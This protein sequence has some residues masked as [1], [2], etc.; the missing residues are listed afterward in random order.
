MRRE[1]AK[2][3]FDSV[4]KPLKQAAECLHFVR[5]KPCHNFANYSF[6]L[7]VHFREQNFSGLREIQPVCPAVLRV[8]AALD[9]AERFH[10]ADNAGDIAFRDQQP[11]RKFLL[12]DALLVVEG[13]QNIELRPG[14]SV[15][16]E[17]PLHPLHVL[18]V[19]SHHLH[20]GLK[21]LVLNGC[22]EFFILHMYSVVKPKRTASETS[23]QNILR[24]NTVF[25]L[26]IFPKPADKQ[27]MDT[28]P[29][30][31]LSQA[32]DLGSARLQAISSNISNVNTPGFKRQDATFAALLDSAQND[33]LAQATPDP[34]DLTGDDD[35]SHPTLT[36][37]Q[38]GSM[39]PDG[40][41]IDID[42]ET[43]RMAAAQIYYEG[44]AQLLSG[45]FS[46]LKYV[47]SGGK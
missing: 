34:R 43:S 45:Q 10:A 29:I 13:G 1:T 30:T 8:R 14:H 33:T 21:H 16:A 2:L 46:N 42:A 35:P 22:L 24:K 39:R 31:A 41:N 37:Q 36:V 19:C 11:R 3:F 47:I 17:D 26:L 12:H 18:R 38:N 20:T 32:L 27:S 44:S 28:T 15:T 23:S 5:L 40:N 9:P 4:F 7:R 25:A 6:M